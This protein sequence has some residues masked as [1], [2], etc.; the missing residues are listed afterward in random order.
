MYLVI[1]R[2]LTVIIF[3]PSSEDP[4][5]H[6][7]QPTVHLALAGWRRPGA[8]LRSTDYRQRATKAGTDV[9]LNLHQSLRLGKDL[10]QILQ[11]H[12]SVNSESLNSQTSAKKVESAF[13]D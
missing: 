1:E 3:P 8:L 11:D 7:L 12:L 9:D 5:V 4:A 10:G 13:I 2:P 6:P